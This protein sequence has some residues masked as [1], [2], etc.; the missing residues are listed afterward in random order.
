MKS[1]AGGNYLFDDEDSLEQYLKEHLERLHSYG[2]N[3]VNAKRFEVNEALTAI[4][5]G[6]LR[7]DPA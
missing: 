3:E 2:I 7:R 4:N 1:R 5:G 6:P